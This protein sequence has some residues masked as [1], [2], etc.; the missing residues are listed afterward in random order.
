MRRYVTLLLAAV[1]AAAVAPAAAASDMPAGVPRNG[2]VAFWTA[3]GHAKDSLGKHHGTLQGNVKYTTG[4]HGKPNGAFLFDGKNGLVKIPDKAELDTDDAF[5]LSL[6][7][8]P[9]A[10]KAKDGHP[11][12]IMDKWFT[13]TAHADYALT[14]EKGRV[15]LYV[16]AGS[17]KEDRVESKCV[18]PKNTWTHIAATFD[19]GA[20]KLYIN[21][22]LE[23]AKV[24]AIVKRTDP[25]E[26]THDDVCIGA[27]CSNAW[28]VDGAINEVGIWNRA[29]GA[30]EIRAVF[31]GL[32]TGLPHVTRGELSDRIELTDGN[33]LSGKIENET[34]SITGL[35]GQIKVPAAR[36]IGLVSGDKADPRVRLVL[37]D[38][39]VVTGRMSGQ[40]VQLTLAAASGPLKVPVVKIRQFGYRITRDKPL[41][42]VG[43]GPIVIL[44]SGDRLAWTECK[45]KLQ[46]RTPAGAV[47]LPIKGVMSI[48][49]VDPKGSAYRV[50]FR[51]GS[52][53][54]G[55]LGPQKLTLKLQLG[56]VATI[57]RQN[58]R[59]LVLAAT[60]VKPTG[61]AT[62]Q[63]R[64]GDR[65]LG[66][67][68]D[69][70]LSVQTEF[71]LTKIR[72]AGVLTMTF[73]A[74]KPTQVVAKMWGNTTI[75]GRLVQ[76]TVTVAIT[77]DGP[78]VKA[79]TTQI[80]S[81]TSTSALLPPEVLKKI[82]KLI[83]QLGAE[84]YVDR[85]KAQK[86]LIAM[87]KSIA[88][89][90]KKHVNSP[91]PEV[92]QRIEQ[93]IKALGG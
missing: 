82:E 52:T 66:K 13:A 88:G 46:L 22:T 25:A 83:A 77:P 39:Q 45:E 59:G 7:I 38:G 69:E 53:L 63:M 18:V 50:V 80:A 62:V 21:G 2:L 48:Q 10:Y 57:H 3:D 89:I 51:N 56:P 71:G 24:S 81:I 92:R 19:R 43:S 29:L 17:R 40:S 30:G 93:I 78:T 11:F 20:M 37:T 84:S 12:H 14:L 6:W 42:P 60:P 68:A 1:V 34:Y 87:G 15:R 16:C 79:K 54:T 33:V 31:D 64:N 65:L 23:A 47:D 28:H 91:D 61:T 55:A 8:N 26:Y 67:L 86:D 44:A 36:V 41:A 49:A 74:A 75:S 85:E 27:N 5:T 9:K 4:R 72:S 76:P 90:L 58:I 73:D 35:F 32:A 70:T